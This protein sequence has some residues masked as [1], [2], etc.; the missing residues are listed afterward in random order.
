MNRRDTL[1]L[2]DGHDLSITVVQNNPDYYRYTLIGT[3][4]FGRA[5]RKNIAVDGTTEAPLIKTCVPP[6]KLKF[7]P[8]IGDELE[9]PFEPGDCVAP[10]TPNT[11]NSQQPELESATGLGELVDYCASL[12]VEA[13][14]LLIVLCEDGESESEI[15]AGDILIDPDGYVYDAAQGTDAVIQGASVTCDMYDEDYQAWER[16]PAELYESQINPQVTGMDGYYAFFVPPGLYRVNATA[17]GYEP[18]TSPDIRVI[19]EVVH[20]N[21]PMQGG[22]SGELFLPMLSR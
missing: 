8:V 7:I 10:S 18:H 6:A 21:I 15:Q 3:S 14:K 17:F 16:W 12:M 22:G 1:S 20:Y 5:V 13:G 9:E 2:D 4:F 11:I 19:N